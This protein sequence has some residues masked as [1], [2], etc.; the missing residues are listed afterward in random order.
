MRTPPPAPAALASVASQ[1]ADGAEPA[2]ASADEAGC[3]E[4]CSGSQSGLAAVTAANGRTLPERTAGARNMSRAGSCTR[5]G[6]HVE[7]GG[8]EG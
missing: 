8:W 3:G 1:R 7:G 5:V 6:S 4:A 2:K